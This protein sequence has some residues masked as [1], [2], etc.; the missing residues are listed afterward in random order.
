H[1]RANRGNAGFTDEERGKMTELLAAGFTDTFR[2]LY[3]DR[4]D[5]YT[6]WSYLYNARASNAGW[7]IDY[8][9]VSDAL[10]PRVRD[11]VI[12][13]NVFGSDHCPV[14]LELTD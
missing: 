6:W 12:Y 2:W 10:R 14:G 4:T 3:P 13:S 9:I 7:R 8:F 1:P 11:S 5:A